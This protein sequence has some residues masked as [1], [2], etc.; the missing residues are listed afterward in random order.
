[1][2]GEDLSSYD[3]VGDQESR[4]ID[5]QESLSKLEWELASESGRLTGK[6][7]GCGWVCVGGGGNWPQNLRESQ[8][9]LCTWGMGEVAFI[10]VGQSQGLNNEGLGHILKE[11]LS[12]LGLEIFMI[13]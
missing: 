11:I 9:E 2:D 5:D 12:F 7:C 6:V 8:V 1:M 4:N 13:A 3:T 10:K